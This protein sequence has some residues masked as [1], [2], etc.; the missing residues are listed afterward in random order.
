MKVETGSR[1]LLHLPLSACSAFIMCFLWLASLPVHAQQ[2][3]RAAGATILPAEHWAHGVLERLA[4]ARVGPPGS[5]PAAATIT[6][7]DAAAQLLGAAGEAEARDQALQWQVLAWLDRLRAEYPHAFADVPVPLA[8][9][10]EVAV[11]ATVHRKPLLARR[12][13]TSTALAPDTAS[14]LGGLRAGLTLAERVQLEL[15]VVASADGVQLRE[16]YGAGE[17]LGFGVWA[18]RRR[19]GFRTAA[20]GGV[21][22]DR[23]LA[24]D[25]AGVRLARPIRLP[26]L[27]PFRLETFLA[28]VDS[29]GSVPAPWLWST[30]A[31]AS[32]GRG[33]T[34][35]ATRALLFGDTAGGRSIR[36]REVARM[37]VGANSLDA[38]DDPYPDNQLVAVDG[39]FRLPTDPLPLEL[40]FVWAVEDGAGAWW[41]SPAITGGIHVPTL[42]GAPAFAVGVEHSVFTGASGHG[43]LY[44]HFFLTGGWA[45]Q[46]VL[47]GHPLG[48]TGREWLVRGSFDHDRGPAIAA[49]AFRRVRPLGN[50]LAPG[51]AGTSWGGSGEVSWVHAPLRWSG[52]GAVELGDGWRTG[53]AELKLEW[54]L[55]THR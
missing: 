23:A 55:G 22:V 40:Y 18:G 31:S 17:L 28:A 26:L 42:P 9:R 41:D 25:G 38:P 46:R 34:I 30:R 7:A 53:S 33:F 50:R 48:G 2:P 36:W 29:N 47:I 24:W 6:V 14:A 4:A 16:A 49:R 20:G 5:D 43:H 11:G 12:D 39:R 21:V 15:D 51:R 8:A 35:A 37:L 10:A 19:T 27:G 45:D 44:D 54:L 3:N 1:L 52:R 13:S 32:P